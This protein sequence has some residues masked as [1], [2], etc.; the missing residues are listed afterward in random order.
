MIRN[1]LIALALLLAAPT[2]FGAECAVT[3][4]GNDA[5][6]F[7][8]DSIEVSKPCKEF[9]INLKHVGKLAKNVM[10]H[11]VVIAATADMNGVNTDGMQAGLENDYVKPDDPRVIAHTKMIGGGESASVSFDPAKLKDGTAYSFFCSFPGHAAL[12]KG[13]VNLVP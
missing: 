11:N 1:S 3:I 2:A 4:E 6:Q 7:N 13:T 8:L 12:M 10:G 5:M 9:T